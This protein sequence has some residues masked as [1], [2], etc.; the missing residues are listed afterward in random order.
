MSQNDC[1]LRKQLS[2]FYKMQL[3]SLRY[4]ILTN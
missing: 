1:D 4:K 3:S 2:R